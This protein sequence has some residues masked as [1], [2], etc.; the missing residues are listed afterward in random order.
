MKLPI[1]Q[2]PIKLLITIAFSG[3]INSKNSVIAVQMINEI[4]YLRLKC[5]S[6]IGR[7]I[8]VFLN[9]ELTAK[10]THHPKLHFDL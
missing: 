7:F 4:K 10:S 2:P 8:Y 9:K 1:A 5:G 3:K 6:F